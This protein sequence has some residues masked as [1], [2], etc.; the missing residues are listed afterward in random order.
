[1]VLSFLR[2]LSSFYEARP[3]EATHSPATRKIM[4][5]IPLFS[6]KPFSWNG[7]WT[8]LFS[9]II[10]LRPLISFSLCAH[11]SGKTKHFLCNTYIACPLLGSILVPEDLV[12][13]WLIIFYRFSTFLNTKEKVSVS[14]L[15][16]RR[17]KCLPSSPPKSLHIY[18]STRYQTCRPTCH[19][20]VHFLLSLWRR[21]E[22]VH[23]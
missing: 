2:Y 17:R 21:F 3:L 11:S 7:C 10:S 16:L 1:M 9:P 19:H 12:Y 20:L 8:F 23:Q 5:Q 6:N 15:F 4:V 13:L 18:R 14:L 22:G